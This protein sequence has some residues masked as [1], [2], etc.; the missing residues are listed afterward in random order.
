M[1]GNVWYDS[2]ILLVE[3]GQYGG[4][5]TAEGASLLVESGQYSGSCTAEG[6]GGESCY[7][8]QDGLLPLLHSNFRHLTCM[9]HI[10]GLLGFKNI[11]ELLFK[12]FSPLK[13]ISSEHRPALFVL[14]VFLSA[15]LVVC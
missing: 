9:Q 13:T 5:C 15:Q 14:G 1:Q 10:F 8:V 12:N 6:F 7:I 4:S 11:L 2:A 3:S